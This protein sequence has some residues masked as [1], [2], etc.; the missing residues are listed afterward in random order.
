MALKRPK[1]GDV[2]LWQSGG[3][4]FL[5]IVAASIAEGVWLEFLRGILIGPYKQSLFKGRK[6]LFTN[7]GPL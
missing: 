4:V 7:L 2:V 3:A 6:R 1:V 5:N